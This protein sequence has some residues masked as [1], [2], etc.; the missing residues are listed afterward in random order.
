MEETLTRAEK[1]LFTQLPDVLLATCD[2]PDE[3]MMM[4]LRLVSQTKFTDNTFYS[5]VR[6]QEA[7]CLAWLEQQPAS[8]QEEQEEIVGPLLPSAPYFVTAAIRK[9]SCDRSERARVNENIEY[10][11]QL[12]QASGLP[13]IDFRDIL[14]QVARET[15][16]P[17]MD[18]FFAR[19]ARLVRVPIGESA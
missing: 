7:T 5:S 6:K 12:Y 14:E 15:T 10:T 3:A 11:M 8:Q 19:L 18:S 2:L 17:G 4:F 13:Q 1:G 16:G 9:A